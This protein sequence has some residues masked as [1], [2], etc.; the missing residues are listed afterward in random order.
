MSAFALP[1]PQWAMIPKIRIFLTFLFISQ[2]MRQKRK[3]PAFFPPKR[4]MVFAD[5]LEIKQLQIGGK[6]KKFILKDNIFF[7]V[8]VYIY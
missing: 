7:L 6:G 2:K 3:K 8:V 4:C 5:G 1:P